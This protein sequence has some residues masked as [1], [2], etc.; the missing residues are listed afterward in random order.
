MVLHGILLQAPKKKAKVAQGANMTQVPVQELDN[1]LNNQA[2]P[3]TPPMEMGAD[4]RVHSCANTIASSAPSNAGDQESTGDIAAMSTEN[5][6]DE[7]FAPSKLLGG[8]RKRWKERRGMQS[9]LGLCDGNSDFDDIFGEEVHSIA[10]TDSLEQ[11]ASLD[12]EH[13]QLG[14]L[15]LDSPSN[16]PVALDEAEVV[17]YE[18]VS[19]DV[20]PEPQLDDA[21]AFDKTEE[22]IGAAIRSTKFGVFKFPWE[23]G[24]LAH[25]FGDSG[26]K[27]LQPPNLQPGGRNFMSMH[28][29][30]SEGSSAEAAVKMKRHQGTDS[31]FAMI[32][33]KAEDI[34]VKQNKMRERDKAVKA[35]W[36][37]L[38]KDIGSSVIGRNAMSE[39]SGPD[40][41]EYAMEILE[42]TFAVKSPGTLMRRLY[43]VQGFADFTEVYLGRCWIPV[44]EFAAWQYVKRLQAD[45]AAATRGASFM[46]S[47]R[48]CWYLLGVDG[49][50][51]VEQSLRIK[52]VAIQMK[53]TKRPWRPADVLSV[54]EV[55]RLHAV[56]EDAGRNLGDRILCGH[57]LH[58]LYSRS[59]WS[60]MLEVGNVFTDSFGCY[61]ELETTS[62]KGA[63]T[64]ELKARLLPIVCP[65]RG[66][67]IVNWV[68]IYL[69]LRNEANLPLLKGDFGP[70]MPVPADR[71][72]RGSKEHSV[73]KRVQSF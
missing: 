60:D 52:G 5:C 38:R 41:D 1:N 15:E 6:A 68:N 42:A 48:F 16:L 61:F 21:P 34:T 18:D 53:A 55:Q 25:V 30:V 36:S 11:P 51:V 59:R 43:A 65:T 45:K 57:M 62:H 56:L 46:E 69:E 3:S 35:W 7:E 31:T 19:G 22:P 4:S 17:V 72:N 9:S 58:L 66:V 67:V 2:L 71:Q 39:V 32:V 73:P 40:L 29:S 70:M 24:R 47:L 33:K 28:V 12:E 26:I 54:V 37:L 8:F 14:S 44:D 13:C 10:C 20:Q 23:K 27:R 49:A 64:A 63:K 50:D